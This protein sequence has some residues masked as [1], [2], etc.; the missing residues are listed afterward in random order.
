LAWVGFAL[1]VVTGVLLFL[2]NASNLYMNLPFQIK[3]V[4]LI[5]AGLNMLVFET[6]TVRHVA[7][8]DSLRPP[9]QAKIA[10]LLSILLWIGVVVAG[11]LIGFTSLADDPFAFI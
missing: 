1:A 8:W 4:L 9:M 11:R 6:M 7:L 10:G 3:M 5:C 2:P